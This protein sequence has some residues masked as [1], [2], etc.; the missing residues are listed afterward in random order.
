MVVKAFDT[1]IAHITV[2]TARGPHY[3]A[4]RTQLSQ[5]IVD[6]KQAGK[7]NFGLK[8]AWVSQIAKEEECY[9]YNGGY[10]Y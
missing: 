4:V 8:V 7:L 6:L 3:A 2:S 5:I 9:G 10:V 1:P